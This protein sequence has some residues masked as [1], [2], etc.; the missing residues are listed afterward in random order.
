ME[1]ALSPEYSVCLCSGL[2]SRA[3]MASRSEWTETNWSRYSLRHPRHVPVWHLPVPLLD[4]ALS[5]PLPSASVA[6]FSSWS[7]SAP[8]QYLWVRW[9]S[10]RV[11]SPRLVGSRAPLK[12]LVQ[13]SVKK[14]VD[15][16]PSPGLSNLTQ[17][18]L[19][20]SGFLG[21][22]QNASR[23]LTT[24]RERLYAGSWSDGDD[25]RGERRGRAPWVDQS[26]R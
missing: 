21:D 14:G 8:H 22:A 5:S 26:V 9:L 13:S 1:F 17:I 10:D 19:F 2:R 20:I 12:P 23:V 3:D 4:A 25:S 15:G 6:H 24:A 7:S 11:V 16:S 18:T